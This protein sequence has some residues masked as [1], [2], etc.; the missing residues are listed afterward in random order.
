MHTQI[1]GPR[2]SVN[3]TVAKLEAA[4]RNIINMK[5]TNFMHNI[6]FK[7]IKILAGSLRTF[8]GVMPSLKVICDSLY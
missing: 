5:G 6:D 8:I 7:K 3:P 1:Q 2:V 4:S